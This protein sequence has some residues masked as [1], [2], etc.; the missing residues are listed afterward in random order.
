NTEFF[1]RISRLYYK[2]FFNKTHKINNKDDMKTFKKD[3]LNSLFY[4]YIFTLNSKG[5][6]DYTY[7]IQDF[8]ISEKSFN[9]KNL[10]SIY[11][12]LQFADDIEDFNYFSIGEILLDSKAIENEYDEFYKLSIFDLLINK[13]LKERYS[14]QKIELFNKILVYL[15]ENKVSFQL[16][17]IYDRLYDNL[18][19]F[20]M[21][22]KEIKPKEENTINQNQKY[23]LSSILDDDYEINY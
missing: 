11:N 15:E 16:K 7:V 4:N 5:F 23:I 14:N 13:P 22:S 20:E 18:S 19:T 21:L 12:L 9:H 1:E 17:S 10:E 8:I 3:L 2:T 6:V